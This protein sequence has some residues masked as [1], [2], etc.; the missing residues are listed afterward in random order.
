ML[1]FA[2]LCKGR[3]GMFGDGSQVAERGPKHG[4][5]FIDVR[6]RVSMPVGRYRW[7]DR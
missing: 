2:R 3:V 7:V 4:L 5:V 1:T 6:L